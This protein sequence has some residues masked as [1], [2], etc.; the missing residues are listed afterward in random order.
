MNRDYSERTLRAVAN[1][2]TVPQV[3][4]NGEH[5]GDSESLQVWLRAKQAA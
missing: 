5:I 1:A 3:Y 2:M 4:V